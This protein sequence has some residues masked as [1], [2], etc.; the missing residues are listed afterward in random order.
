ME[1][2]N[3]EGYSPYKV[4]YRLVRMSKRYIISF[5][6]FGILAILISFV[7]V[8]SVEALRRMVNGAAEHNLKLLVN[9]LLL[10]LGIF[11]VNFL[12]NAINSYYRNLMNQ[13]SVINFQSMIINKFFKAKTSQI[14]K[15]HTSDVISRIKDN[16]TT[17]IEGS[18][19]NIIR[20][21]ELIATI[22]LNL[23]YISIIDY[24]IAL[25]SFLIS[26]TIPFLSNF[27]AGFVRHINDEQWKSRSELSA[28][29]QDSVQGIEVIKS[30]SLFE[31]LRLMHRKVFNRILKYIKLGA[32]M[33][34]LVNVPCYLILQLG[35]I[36]VL[37]YGGM[38][39][40]KGLLDVGS[41]VALS[42]MYGK[43]SGPIADL[44]SIWPSFQNTISAANRAFE[45][46]DLTDESE[47]TDTCE[48]ELNN[49]KPDTKYDLTFHNVSFNYDNSSNVLNEISFLTK[50]NSLTAL[51]GPSG[52][53]K[54]TIIK[55]L[56]R[57]YDPTSGSILCNGHP[58][59]AIPVDKWRDMIAYV[60]QDPYLFTGTIYDNIRYGNL[61]ATREQIE[62]AAR[63]SNISDLIASMPEGYQTIIG[64][65]GSSLSGGE[66]QRLS[67]A[68][69]FLKNPTI[70]ILDEP[71]SSLDSENEHI[72]QQAL[73]TLMEGKTII[74]VAHRLSTLI[75]ADNIIYMEEGCIKESGTHRELIAMKGKYYG[76]YKKNTVITT[77]PESLLTEDIEKVLA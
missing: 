34:N 61:H 54:T 68:R 47:V 55:L 33:V 40:A 8:A 45:I 21:I 18:N 50:A 3:K 59:N 1:N 14:N 25:L 46:V 77:N 20:V 7:G 67:I 19:N 31:Q 5:I 29:I 57:L 43:I 6:L 4:F 30:Y 62:E 44:F 48:S 75:D 24:K 11:L 69:A 53:G 64:E 15:Y 63:I 51:A 52:S 66:K 72:I 70:L 22:V 10:S 17:V 9:G 65:R 37:G 35:N 23:V 42:V 2:L 27:L 76:Q 12:L 58:I 28:L 49:L 41:V 60:S 73:N 71:T 74:M 38:Q 39:V 36:V 26:T 13:S 16:S 56:L 32:W